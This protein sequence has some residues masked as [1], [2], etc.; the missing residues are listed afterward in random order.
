MTIKNFVKEEIDLFTSNFEEM[1]YRGDFVGMGSYYADD[2]KLFAENTELVQGRQQ[3]EHFWQIS[4]ERGKK[5]GMKR[6]IH[7]LEFETS[8]ELGYLTA[9]VNLLIPQS[10]NKVITSIIRDVIV[11]RKET[12]GSW[13]IL[14]DIS[15]QKPPQ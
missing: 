8:G 11:W 5:I 10:D 1:F 14:I 13:R 12:D 4:S 3:L 6:T 9:I 2:A 7:V 15:N